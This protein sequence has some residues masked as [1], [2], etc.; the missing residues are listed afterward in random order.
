[1]PPPRRSRRAPEASGPFTDRPVGEVWE[2]VG[3]E[4]RV[5]LDAGGEGTYRVRA[6]VVVGD[7]VAIEGG[8]VTA[9]APR[10]T[11]LRRANEGRTAVVV[12]NATQLV[13]VAATLDPPFRTGLVD[14]ILVAASDAGLEAAIVLNKC[15]AGMPE[16]VLERVAWYEH[17]GYPCFLVSAL[18]EKGLDPLRDFLAAERTVLTGH[19]GVGKTALLNALVPGAGRVSGSL[20]AWGRGRHT[21]TAA[22]MFALPEGGRVIDLPGV[23]AYGLDFVLREELR[24]HFPELAGIPCRYADCLHDGDDGCIAEDH[25]GEQRL[26]SYRKLLGELA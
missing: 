22:V 15:D 24:H 6:P 23:R 25:A 21:T 3:K 5:V 1:M 19:S 4:V 10:T 18:Q 20:D 2:M 14:R 9:Y 17:L 11:E 8:L 26:E 16:E 7:R 13:V 12:A